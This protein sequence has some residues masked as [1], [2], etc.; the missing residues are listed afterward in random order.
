MSSDVGESVTLNDHVGCS[1]RFLSRLVV[2]FRDCPSRKPA[3]IV[4]AAC[5]QTGLPN[6]ARC[7]NIDREV[8]VGAQP[9]TKE[10][11]ALDDNDSFRAY[12]NPVREG[13][14]R[15]VVTLEPCH[16]ASAQRLQQLPFEAPVIE[17]PLIALA[18]APRAPVTFL[19]TVEI[20][21]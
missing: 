20:I 7:V 6:V 13:A 12:V 17:V 15:P 2:V 19:G 16:Q 1:P 18:R 21:T 11:D 3:A 9:S 5:V 4:L 8:P 10:I 14:G